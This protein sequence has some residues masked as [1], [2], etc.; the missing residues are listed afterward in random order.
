MQPVCSEVSK[1]SAVFISTVVGR[2]CK[3]NVLVLDQVSQ[4]MWFDILDKYGFLF[5]QE[6]WIRVCQFHGI[7]NL[8]PSSVAGIAACYAMQ[9]RNSRQRLC[10]LFGTLQ[11]YS[12][13]YKLTPISFDFSR[14]CAVN[15]EWDNHISILFNVCTC[16]P[17]ENGR[18]CTTIKVYGM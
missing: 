5:L 14:I 8:K 17:Y 16:M 4:I 3:A 10:W 2:Q 12:V 1:K 11:N 15:V 6:H 18:N 7:N 13:K 9:L